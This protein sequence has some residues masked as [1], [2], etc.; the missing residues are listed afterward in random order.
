MVYNLININKYEVKMINW[1]EAKIST[2]TDA[3]DSISGILLSIGISGFVIE[4]A[5]DFNEFLTST[6]YR[7][8]YIDEE[9]MQ[10]QHSPTSITVYI[11]ENE[12]GKQWLI[13]IK[14]RLEAA[15]LS[16][17][18]INF[19]TLEIE[20][21]NIRE[22]DWANNWKQYFKPFC[23]GDKLLIKPTWESVG[24]TTDRTV[25]NIDPG[26]SFGTGQHHTT[27]LCLERLEEIVKGGEKVLDLGAGSGILSIGALLLGA[28]SAVGIDIDENSVRVAKENAEQ[29]G[30]D[31][32]FNAMCGNIIDDVELREKI[33]K[34]YDIVVANIVADVIILMSPIFRE[35]MHENSTL[36]VSGII[37]RQKDE[38][39]QALIENGFEIITAQE[40]NDWSCIVC[41]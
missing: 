9:L 27:K 33:G 11:P 26:S 1:I 6:E 37:N 18:E 16:S 19:G 38:V 10:R 30:V 17:P 7:W 35:F 5:N 2:T 15:K 28:E 4:D 29:N 3:I 22:E 25:L 40:S 14:D 24:N 34:N 23:V 12:Q 39:K 31:S 32:H 36:I 8:D 20:L 13:E 21:K 41:R